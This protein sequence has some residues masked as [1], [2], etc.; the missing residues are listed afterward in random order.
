MPSS[1][2]NGN[3]DHCLGTITNSHISLAVTFNILFSPD[4]DQQQQ[5]LSPSQVPPSASQLY[6]HSLLSATGSTFFL[7][8]GVTFWWMLYFLMRLLWFIF[9]SPP[10]ALHLSKPT[11]FF[12]IRCIASHFIRLRDLFRLYSG[13]CRSLFVMLTSIC[14]MLYD[15]PPPYLPPATFFFPFLSPATLRPFLSLHT[16]LSF[17][18][19]YYLSCYSFSLTTDTNRISQNPRVPVAKPVEYDV[20]GVRVHYFLLLAFRQFLFVS[21]RWLLWR[22]VTNCKCGSSFVYNKY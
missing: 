17:S 15:R 10:A 3:N 14:F 2:N 18:T 19:Q 21:S 8:S 11:S 4:I 9:V 1:N 20:P 16:E 7:W 5:F 13:R 6:I 22:K 12:F